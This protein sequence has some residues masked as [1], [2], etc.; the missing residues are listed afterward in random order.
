M[1]LHIQ[2]LYPDTKS[3]V[4]Q[5]KELHQNAYCMKVTNSNKGSYQNVVKSRLQD[6]F[7]SEICT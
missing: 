1:K 3:C 7:V 5:N 6:A 4:W 2:K